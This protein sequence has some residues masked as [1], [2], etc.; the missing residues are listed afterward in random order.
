MNKKLT[1]AALAAAAVAASAFTSTSMSWDGSDTEGKVITGSDEETAGYWYFYDDNAAPNNGDSKIVFPSDVEENTYGNFFGPLCEA[2]GGIKATIQI[3]TAYEYPFVGFG[4]NIVSENQE[5]A[6]ISA[7]GGIALAYNSTGGFAVEL[8]VEDEANVTEY[9]NYKATAAK[10]SQ[11]TSI[12]WA[13][14]K[15]EAGWGQKVDQDVVLSKT[16]AIKLK[17]TADADFLLTC[18]ADAKTG[19]GT[20]AIKA[21]SAQGALNAQLNGRTLSFGKTVKAELVNLQG[22]VIASVNASSM[23]LSKVQAGVYMVRAEGLSQR[24]MVK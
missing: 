22:Q 1:L 3:G 2:Y 15:Q 7:W 8:G 19:C 21:A 9:N 6:D 11:S 4:F 17:F 20:G 14:F 12:A 23:D 5:G 10:G 16:A 18:I 13:K 24:I